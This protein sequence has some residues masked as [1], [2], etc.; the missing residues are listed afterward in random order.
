MLKKVPGIGSGWAKTIVSYGERLGGYVAV[1]QLK[2]IEGFPVESLPFFEVR[3]AQNKT[4]QISNTLFVVAT[5]SP[6]L[7]NLLYGTSD[8]RI[9]TT[10]RQIK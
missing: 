3:N 5:A 7:H 9:Q 1:G 4:S 10:E 8:S 2:E 6:P